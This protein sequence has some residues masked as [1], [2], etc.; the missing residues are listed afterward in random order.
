MAA[1]KGSA[2]LLKIGSGSPVTYATIG[3]LRST[4]ITMNDEPVDITNKDSAGVRTLLA[5]GGVQSMSVSGS[6]VFTDAASEGTLRTA[7]GAASFSQ[8]QLLIPDFGTYTG[9]FMIASLEY[10]GEYNGEV[11]Y[12]VTLESSGA[13][14]FA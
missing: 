1:Q 5:Q 2:L 4:S 6:G 7:F 12:S 8:Y 10:A 9:T 14:T 11:T 13:V 3:G